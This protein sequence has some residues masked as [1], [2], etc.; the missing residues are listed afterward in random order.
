MTTVKFFYTGKTI[1]GFSLKGHSSA[2]CSDEEGRLVC[3]AVS[4][5]AYMVANTLT[6]IFGINADIQVDEALMVLKTEDITDSAAKVLEGFKLHMEGL[7][8]QYSK[9][10]KVYSEV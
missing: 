1:T 3:S 7:S 5:A 10:I 2:N 8:S 9:S 6:E 4:S